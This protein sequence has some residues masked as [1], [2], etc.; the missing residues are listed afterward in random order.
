MAATSFSRRI[1]LLA[2]WRHSFLEDKRNGS[3]DLFKAAAERKVSK[4]IE[5]A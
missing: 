1:C 3:L 2:L 4:F 5:T